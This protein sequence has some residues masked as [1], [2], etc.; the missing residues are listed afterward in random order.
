MDI[1]RFL[2]PDF[3]AGSE[4]HSEPHSKQHRA[5]FV[6]L[7]SCAVAAAS[8]GIPSSRGRGIHPRGHSV[9]VRQDKR[10]S[11]RTGARAQTLRCLCSH[12]PDP[13]LA[14]A[15]GQG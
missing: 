13:K 4:L 8:R 9:R 14:R 7:V 5:E 15:G 1:P 2:N 3:S 6:G 11:D 12:W 10:E